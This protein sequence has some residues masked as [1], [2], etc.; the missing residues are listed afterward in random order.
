MLDIGWSELLLV[1]VVAIVV[2]GPKDLPDALRAL[3]RTLTKLRRMAGEFQGQFNA[4]LR[5]A[6]LED[7]KKEFDTIREQTSVLKGG[8][9]PVDIARNEIK[10]AITGPAPVV[11][12]TASAA[13]IDTAL[14]SSA[15]V[16]PVPTPPSAV[17]PEPPA[18]P[19]PAPLRE[20]IP[21]AFATS[22]SFRG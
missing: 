22:S 3:G 2:I 7:V 13:T 16:E 18:G 20:P 21:S 17:L 5:E 10:G 6:N 4:A 9:N 15:P 19:A 14:T 1:A 8:F 12:D 11:A